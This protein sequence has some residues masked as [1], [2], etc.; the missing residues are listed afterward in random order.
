MCVGPRF[1]PPRCHACADACLPV[2]TGA[3]SLHTPGNANHA[4]LRLS[5]MVSCR[6]ARD[7][8]QHAP[9][10]VPA[11]R[12]PASTHTLPPVVIGEYVNV[13]GQRL[14]SADFM[15][16]VSEVRGQRGALRNVQQRPRTECVQGCQS[17]GVPCACWPP[18]YQ[19]RPWLALACMHA[20]WHVAR[21][22][23]ARGGMRHHLSPTADTN[24]KPCMWR[25]HLRPVLFRSPGRWYCSH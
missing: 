10:L 23:G 22:H 6:P 4:S 9:S 1:R 5:D 18:A 24:T 11:Q 19:Y 13:F 12:C 17:S 8:W 25:G 15:K 3:L 16:R 7:P 20:Q 2:R 14:G 21:W